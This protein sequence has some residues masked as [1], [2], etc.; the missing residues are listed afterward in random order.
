MISSDGSYRSALP[1]AAVLPPIFRPF[2]DGMRPGEGLA[3]AWD[4]L[5]L[6]KGEARVEHTPGS[7]GVLDTPKSGHGRTVDLG[8]AAVSL[9]KRLQVAQAEAALL[10]GKP[11][12]WVF[13]GRGGERMPIITAQVAF[14][15]VLRASGLPAER[16]EMVAAAGD[17]RPQGQGDT[18]SKLL[19][20][21]KL[22]ERE[23]FEPSVP[24]LPAHV[25]S[26]HADSTTL[27]SLRLRVW[28][29]RGR[30]PRP[31]A[32][33]AAVD[34]AALATCLRGVLLRPPLG[35]RL[36]TDRLQQTNGQP[37]DQERTGLIQPR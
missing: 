25:I 28:R 14:G 32:R 24:G 6:V 21:N 35:S 23:G 4:N 18:D 30:V 7:N 16:A 3:L 29:R 27:A 1:G 33:S 17:R 36:A 11:C 31:P 19:S 34:A 13:P 20:I 15:R 10:R 5:D 22:A 26:S 2:P 12:P 8:A 9:L 37:L